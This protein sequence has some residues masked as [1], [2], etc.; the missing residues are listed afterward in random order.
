MSSNKKVSIGKFLE[1]DME[2]PSSLEIHAEAICSDLQS[3]SDSIERR[4][5]ESIGYFRDFNLALYGI[6]RQ[7]YAIKI[8][9]FANI[10]ILALILW[11]LW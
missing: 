5:H 3:L 8:A 9:G 4:H 10:I 2:I 7:L 6:N 11:K 1:D